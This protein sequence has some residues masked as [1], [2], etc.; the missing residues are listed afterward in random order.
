M[1]S[2]IVFV[3]FFAAAYLHAQQTPL[4]NIYRH[5]WALLNAA[6]FPRNYLED[7]HL[8]THIGLVTRTQT[9]FTEGFPQHYQVRF[10]HILDLGNDKATDM[11]IG[12]FV[13]RDQ[14]GAWGENRIQANY[15]YAFSTG[16]NQYFSIGGTLGFIQQRIQIDRVNWQT[17]PNLP[18]NLNSRWLMDVNMGVFYN[19]RPGSGGINRYSKKHRTRSTQPHYYGGISVSQIIS[20]RLDEQAGNAFLTN[21]KPHYYAV[22]GGVF[23][24]FEPTVW[25]RYLPGAEY[26]TWGFSNPLSIDLNVRKTMQ[27]IWVGA[28]LSTN[29]TANAEFGVDFWVGKSSRRVGDQLQFAL[30]LGNLSLSKLAFGGGPNLE[31]SGSFNF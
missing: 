28:G 31:L 7:Q 3:M 30:A 29:G 11:K 27:Q 22:A 26:S 5:N 1:R 9:I 13:S 20:S 14:A 8:L 15:A 17:T 23:N 25:L 10:E 19:S 24:G 21:L 2:F 12:L 16:R 18:A 6:A 4:I